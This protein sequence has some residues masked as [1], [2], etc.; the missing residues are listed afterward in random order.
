MKLRSTSPFTTLH[1]SE[2]SL[3]VGFS[4]SFGWYTSDN[5]ELLLWIKPPTY[6]SSGAV[7]LVMASL[8]PVLN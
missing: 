3:A 4:T 5:F 1:E 6:V 2:P 8:K 7:M